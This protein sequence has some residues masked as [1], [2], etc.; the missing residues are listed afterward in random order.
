MG[1]I[2]HQISPLEV[3]SFESGGHGVEG[4]SNRPERRW[5]LLGH[6]CREITVRHPV[7]GFDDAAKRKADAPKHG[8]QHA[9]D[10]DARSDGEQDLSVRARPTLSRAP[11]NRRQE[12]DNPEDVEEEHQREDE[13]DASGEPAAS[14]APHPRA[15]IG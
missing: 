3:L 14:P 1:D 15:R 7:R 13:R 11:N 8:E 10:D 12:R 4:P 6:S 2:R 5:A 9:E